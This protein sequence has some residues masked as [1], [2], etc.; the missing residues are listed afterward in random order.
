M[1]SDTHPATFRTKA[2]PLTVTEGGWLAAQQVSLIA[3]DHVEL[4]SSVRE[5]RTSRVGSPNRT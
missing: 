1:I 3:R 5:T 2:A 4:V